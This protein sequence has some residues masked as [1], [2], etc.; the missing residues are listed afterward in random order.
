MIASA[1][2]GTNSME[3]PNIKSSKMNILLWNCR[4][5]LNGDF[6]R[7][8]FEMAVNHFPAIMIIT[9]TRVGGDRATKIIEGLPFD[10]FFVTETI[11]YAGGLCLLW[12]KE[13]VEVFVLA[14]TE[15]EIHATIKVCNSDFT[16]LISSIYAS[17]RLAERKILWANLSQVALLHNLPWLLLG[18]FNE[19]LCE[20]DKLGGRQINLNRALEFKSCM[21]DCNFLDLGFSGPKF[22]WSNRRQISDLI[23]ERIDRCFANPAWRTLYP[24]ASVTHLPRVFSDHYPVL[25]ELS[26]PPPT[27]TAKPFRFHTMWMHHPDFPN[28][29][30]KTWE[31]GLDLHIAIK[32]FADNAKQWNR[33]V[34]GNI[35]ARKKRVLARINGAQKALSNGPSHFLIQLEKSLIDEYNLIMQQEEE[36]W[37]LKSRLN[38]AAYGDSNTSFFSCLHAGQEA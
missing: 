3:V 4:G 2:M 5:A 7:R 26:R 1:M 10:G 23:L 30:R 18:D 37:A 32:S 6:T 19:I 29:V 34:F 22:T 35:F 31:P 33:S 28:V 12:K 20:N 27:A 24:E 11:G 14:A 17:P 15:Q 36:Y 21:D 8:V 38:W 25:L 9:E 13:E 16:W